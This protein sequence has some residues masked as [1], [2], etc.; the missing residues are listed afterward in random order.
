[1]NMIFKITAAC[2]LI[3]C[4]ACSKSNDMPLGADAMESVKSETSIQAYLFAHNEVAERDPSGVYYRILT[5]G[6]S[7]HFP[8]PTSVVYV[9]YSYQL[10]TGA[11]VATSFDV[12]NFNNRQLKNHIPGWQIGLQKI[13]KGGKIRLY[14]PPAL[15][16]G[17]IGVPNVVP[18][19]A[20]LISEVELVD[21]K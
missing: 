8:K 10:T 19:D 13:S 21:I 11:I 4:F 18:P 14:I 17:S 1:M 2:L 7:I 6:D 15:A 9:K 12:T 3:C 20:I 5:P 16:F